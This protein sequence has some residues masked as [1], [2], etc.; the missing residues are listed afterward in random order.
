MPRSGSTLLQ[1]IL[2]NNPEIY[3]TPTSP[4]F[5]YINAVRQSYSN[6]P[7]VKAQNGEEMKSALY[8]YC[9]YAVEGYFVALTQRPYVVDKSRNWALNIPFLEKFYPN[10]KII[11][12]VRDLRDVVASMEKNY[13][14]HPDKMTFKV[15]DGTTIGERVTTW[16]NNVPVGVTLKNLKEVIH[17]GNHEKMLFIRYEDLCQNPDKEMK[18]VYK[19]LDL[20]YFKINYDNVKQVTFE[21]DKFHGIYGDHIIKE[22]IVPLESK[23]IHLLGEEI[24][25]NL[26]EKNKWYFDYFKYKK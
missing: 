25:N 4:L 3:A 14:K 20:P 2:G 12:M 7:T 15:G 22:K 11:C 6:S 21:D 10:P 18:K 8:Y 23:H 5:E 17:R 1:N 19:F 26:Y 24:S 16:M 13:Q 9:R